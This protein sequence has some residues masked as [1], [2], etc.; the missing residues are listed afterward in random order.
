MFTPD[1]ASVIY[2]AA[3]EGNP[4][5][6]FTTRIDG[7]DSR[8]LGLK[9]ANVVAVS[10]RGEIAVLRKS[11]DTR[12]TTGIGEGTLATV[13]LSGGEPRDVL[14]KVVA[15]DWNPEGTQMAIV[16]QRIPAAAAGVG[17]P[18]S[19]PSSF[20]SATSCIARRLA[21]RASFA[22]HRTV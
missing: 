1:A 6:V 21:S 18:P 22:F 10:S 7:T 9:N 19:G 16:R 2:A 5:E 4:A 11:A 13:S 8:P 17:C 3:W 20:R 15:A 12:W 14:D